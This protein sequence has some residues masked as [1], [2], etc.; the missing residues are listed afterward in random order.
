MTYQ[1]KKHNEVFDKAMVKKNAAL[2]VSYAIL[3]T[4][5]QSKPYIMVNYQPFC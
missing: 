2:H 5:Y 3:D 1:N 4:D